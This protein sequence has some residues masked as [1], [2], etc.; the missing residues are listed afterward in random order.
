MCV[1]PK[2][3]NVKS[4]DDQRVFFSVIEHHVEVL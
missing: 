3:K 1:I 2:L 4:Q